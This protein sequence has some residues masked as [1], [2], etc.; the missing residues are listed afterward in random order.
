MN[1]SCLLEH[2]GNTVTHPVNEYGD[3]FEAAKKRCKCWFCPECCEVMGYNLR[4][5]LFPILASFSYLLLVT[6][7]VDPSLFTDPKSAYLYIMQ[8]RCIARTIQDLFRWG[9]LRSRRYFCVIEWHKKTGYIHLHVLLDSSYIPIADLERSW[10]KHRPAGAGPHIAGR[11]LFGY[12]Y[13]SKREFEGGPAHA[14]RYVTKYLTKTPEHG[15]P[16][17]VLQMKG[18]RIRRYSASRGFW[19]TT[20]KRQP[21]SSVEHERQEHTYA[22]RVQ[23]CGSSVNVFEIRESVDRGTGEIRITRTWAGELQVDANEVFKRLFDPGEPRRSCRTLLAL[24]L[25]HVQ[26]IISI[27]AGHDAAWIRGGQAHNDPSRDMSI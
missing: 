7:T 3:H 4:K 25:P 20:T 14:A 21:E 5:R 23:A 16:D 9:H 22:E 6:L 26:K 17:W 27:A 12:V 24:S 15:F 13:I 11:P 19:G 8:R 2:V 18:K 10:G 1:G